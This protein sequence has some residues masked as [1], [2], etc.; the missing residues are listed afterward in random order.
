MTVEQ[1]EL[2]RPVRL[3]RLG[4]SPTEVSIVADRKA[5]E[6]LAER[7][8]LEAIGSL[9]ARVTI[10]R[11]P[12]SGWIEVAGTV[13]ADVVQ[14]CVVTTEP[15]P[16]AVTAELTELFDDSGEVAG[17]EVILDPMA[18]TPEPI[19]GDSIDVGE[20]V[21]QALGLALDPYPRAPGAEPAVTVSEPED[22]S[23]DSPFARLA[24]I[25]GRQEEKG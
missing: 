1:P 20:I 15:V 11:R 4:L 12:D 23:S 3:D 14:T 8:E 24:A 16:A 6:A 10:R 9:R 13:E 17:D 21:A 18:D 7:F 5:C 22:V 19:S 25:R 2:S